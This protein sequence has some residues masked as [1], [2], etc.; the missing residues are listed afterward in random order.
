V[1]AHCT[2]PI[3]Q[4]HGFRAP[5]NEH[6][7]NDSN[8]ERSISADLM[9]GSSRPFAVVRAPWIYIRCAA[10]AAAQ[11]PAGCLSSASSGP[12][13]MHFQLFPFAQ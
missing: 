3:A 7:I 12:L 2:P 5:N 13:R 8:C 6:T 4:P 10:R 1:R 9:A 11:W